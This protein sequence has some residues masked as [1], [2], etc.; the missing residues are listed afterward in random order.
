M[1]W[2]LLISALLAAPAIGG[3][4]E[5][6]PNESAAT[7]LVLVALVAMVFGYHRNL[8]GD[9]GRLGLTRV[10]IPNETDMRVRYT[11]WGLPLSDARRVRVGVDA[12]RRVRNHPVRA[13]IAELL[14]AFA[15]SLLKRFGV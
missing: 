6:T 2:K 1:L 11:I 7:R 3:I 4:L 8:V 14:P 13:T 10:S 5:A 9:D 15:R 12:R